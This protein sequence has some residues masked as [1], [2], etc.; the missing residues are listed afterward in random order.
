MSE[1]CKLVGVRILMGAGKLIHLSRYRHLHLS[2]QHLFR[3]FR[4]V[5]AAR[6]LFLTP[7]KGVSLA[8]VVFAQTVHQ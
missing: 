3:V 4:V 8:N 7:L 2:R 6:L 1:A 5:Q